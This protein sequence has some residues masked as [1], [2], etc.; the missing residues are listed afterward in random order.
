MLIVIPTHAGDVDRA[1]SVA[2]LIKTLGG[3]AGHTARIVAAESVSSKNLGELK[4]ILESSFRKVDVSVVPAREHRD[5][6]AASP[7]MHTPAANSMFQL[8]VGEVESLEI[9]TPW[10]YLEPDSTPI[11][12]G[13]IDKLEDAYQAGCAKGKRI[14]GSVIPMRNYFFKVEN[15]NTPTERGLKRSLISITEDKK[16]TYSPT[17]MVFPPKYSSISSLYKGSKLSPWEMTSSIELSVHV[18]DT[19]II[20]HAHDSTNYKLDGST[21][22]F[23]RAAGDMTDRK[24]INLKGVSL[25]HGNRDN[26]LIEIVEKLQPKSELPQFVGQTEEEKVMSPREAAL[27]ARNKK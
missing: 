1:I 24:T 2:K 12:A 16:E 25:I 14:L 8:T 21:V 3:A 4:S 19:D 17:P 27:A 5:P 20:V 23:D 9:S 13:W 11:H 18:Q 7:S 26:S 10:L 22:T 15:V 6:L